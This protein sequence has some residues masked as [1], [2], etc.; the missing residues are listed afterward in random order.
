MFYIRFP[1]QGTSDSWDCNRNVQTEF[2]NCRYK[3]LNQLFYRD[4]KAAIICYDICDA[5]TWED[6]KYW[7]SEL[8][9][10]EEVSVNI[11]WYQIKVGFW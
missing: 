5:R 7:L 4:A 11:F 9:L 1:N 2:L 6:V 10:H 3:S 8:R